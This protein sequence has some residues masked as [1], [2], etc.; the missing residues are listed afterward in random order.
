MFDASKFK[1]TETAVIEME[2]ADGTPIYL[3]DAQTTPWTI[4]I[5]GPGTKIGMQALHERQK[6]QQSDVFNQM[7]GKKSARDESSDTKE[8]AEFLMKIFRST[9]ADNLVYEGHTGTD[10]LRAIFL[11]PL[12]SHCAVKLDN[13]FA[14]RGNFKPASSTTSS[15]TSDTLPG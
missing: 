7:K 10:A 12:M 11:D 3:D 4:T 13:A 9:N 15:S 5:A 8:R 1:M 6:A 2:E 14:D